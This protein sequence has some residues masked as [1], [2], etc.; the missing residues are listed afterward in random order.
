MNEGYEPYYNREEFRNIRK[1][2]KGKK[3]WLILLF[4]L[5]LIGLGV[6][7]YFLFFN[8][9]ISKKDNNK[10]KNKVVEKKKLQ[11]VDEDSNK[12]PIAVMI[13]NNVGNNAHAGLNKAYITYECIV[14]GGMTRIMAIFKDRDVSLIGPVRSSRHYFLDYALE[15]DAIYAHYGWSPFAQRD[16]SSLGVNNING[17]YDDAPYWRDQAIAAPHNVFTSTDKLYETAKN[18]KYATTSDDWKLLNYTTDEVKLNTPI[19]TKDVVDEETGKTK[20]VDEYDKELLEAN[21]VVVRYS[22]YHIR[23]Y[24]YDKENKRYVRFMNNVAHTDKESGE[25]LSYKNV[26]I[27]FV[28]NTTLDN[29]GRQDL[30]TVASGGGYFITNGYALPINWAKEGRSDKTVYTYTNGKTVEFNDGNT[31]IQVAPTTYKAEIS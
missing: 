24:E 25:Q 19:G 15:S 12:R 26:V 28:T 22:N 18:K 11:I 7:A 20:K 23:S 1:R 21:K 27:M 16:I 4:L 3:K 14:E 5:V 13:D 17:L 31:I 6:G 8:K 9:P 10:T 2:K 29:E 30:D